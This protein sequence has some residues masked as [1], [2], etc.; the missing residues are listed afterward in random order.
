MNENIQDII[1]KAKELSNCIRNHR[2]T[3]NFNDFSLKMKSDSCA[4]ELYARMVELGKEINS[5]MLRD[6]GY[7][8]APSSE[9]ALLQKDLD[10]TPL[11]KEYIRSQKEYLAL[12]QKVIERI[13]N[14]HK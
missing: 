9:Y 13:K 1:E 4:Q 2:I 8:T 6:D 11:V 5:C 12:L 7:Q 3:R 10:Q 14:P